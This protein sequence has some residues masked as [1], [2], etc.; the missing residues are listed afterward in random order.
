MEELLSQFPTRDENATQPY[1]SFI[2][3]PERVSVNSRQSLQ[4]Q[5]V[6]AAELSADLYNSFKVSLKTPLLRVKAVQ[7]LRATIPNAVPSIP[8]DECFF[9]YYRVPIAAGVVPQ[10][11][12]TQY[13]A[14]NIYVVYLCP[15][16]T[17]FNQ[18]NNP[19]NY[20]LNRTFQDYEDL[21][22]ALNTAAQVNNFR[23]GARFIAG[24]IGFAYDDVQNKIVMI[25]NNTYAPGGAWQYAYSP[26]G[27]NDPNL[28]IVIAEL[29]NNFAGAPFNVPIS[30]SNEYT[31]NRRLG[32]TF[33]GAFINPPNAAPT[34]QQVLLN[35][36]IL[37]YRTIPYFDPAPTTAKT[38]YAE[39]Y[40][41][42]VNTGNV[43]IYCDVIGGSTQDTNADER[44]L[45]VVPMNASNLGV[46]FG[47]SKM[48]C[49]L[50]KVSE[51]VYDLVFT[52]RDDK[53]KPFYL[54]NNA[55][56]NLEL[57]VEYE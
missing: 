36:T 53:G 17:I 51:V 7:L 28:Q 4:N 44:L 13:I 55:Y 14:N 41:D 2:Y 20:V 3:Q 10:P 50:K 6:T 49:S 40:C 19:T 18:N 21:A 24:D 46:A 16:N 37:L 25:G 30:I 39:N 12:T 15:T 43:F 26:V 34:A 29:L 45:A 33:N 56:V 8:N 48:S 31:L 22:T 23:L 1:R 27:Y 54:P 38:Y 42:L 35:Q 9:F 32:F 5:P 11:D 47:E 57:K 52:M